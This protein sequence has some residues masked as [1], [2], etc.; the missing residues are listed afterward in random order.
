MSEK[1]Q[2]SEVYWK[3]HRVVL[4]SFLQ[5]KKKLFDKIFGFNTGKRHK[6]C[7]LSTTLL[8]Q[9]VF[10]FEFLTPEIKLISLFNSIHIPLLFTLYITDLKKKN[11]DSFFYTL[12]IHTHIFTQTYTV[13]ECKLKRKNP[14]SPSLSYMQTSLFFIGTLKMEMSLILVV[15]NL[16]SIRRCHSFHRYH[17]VNFHTLRYQ[18]HRIRSWRRQWSWWQCYTH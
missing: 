7:K 12:N 14:P 16:R 11:L 4:Y 9:I 17:L 5:Q 8:I 10:L 13:S 3:I 6:I 18:L 2:L 15:W 1:L